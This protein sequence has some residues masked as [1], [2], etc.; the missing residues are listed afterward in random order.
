MSENGDNI[1]EI[2]EL[3]DVDCSAFVDTGSQQEERE[4]GNSYENNLHSTFCNKNL[5]ICSDN[6]VCEP[7]A[8]VEEIVKSA[9]EIP[10]N[11]TACE[12]NETVEEIVKPSCEKFQNKKVLPE[13]KNEKFSPEIVKIKDITY[14]TLKKEGQLR[15]H[16]IEK[17]CSDSSSD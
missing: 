3:E 16:K 7:T 2:S 17:P 10:E 12:P 15:G 4:V 11:K 14:K 5:D 1:S 6:V 8:N 13:P 9:C